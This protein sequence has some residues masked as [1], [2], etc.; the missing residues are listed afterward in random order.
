MN[1]SAIKRFNFTWAMPGGAWLE[2]DNGSI[3]WFSFAFIE[4][5]LGDI[6]VK[7]QMDKQGWM[8]GCWVEV[9]SV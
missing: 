6:W 1:W 8:T 7:R 4:K 3:N 9:E 5:K 2:D